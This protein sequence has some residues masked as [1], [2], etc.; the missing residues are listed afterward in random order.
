MAKS[1]HAEID[2]AVV[3][4]LREMCRRF[5]GSV[6]DTESVGRPVFKVSKKIYAMQHG[7]DHRMSL[8]FKAPAGM[9]DA[10][11]GREP[12]RYFVPPY[13]GSKGWIGA[14]LDDEPD[15]DALADFVEESYRMTATKKLIRELDAHS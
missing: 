9:Q 1:T 4:R 13:A 14:W 6:E 3:E 8:W 7:A 10:V 11:I 5:P 15:W 12:D 2:E